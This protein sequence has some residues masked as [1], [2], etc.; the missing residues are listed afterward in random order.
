MGSAN[1][2]SEIMIDAFTNDYIYMD[3]YALTPQQPSLNMT[4]LQRGL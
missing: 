2:D 1:E 4:E 3:E